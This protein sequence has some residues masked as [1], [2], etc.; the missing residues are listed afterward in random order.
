MNGHVFC[1]FYGGIDYFSY[2]YVGFILWVRILILHIF[3]LI[4]HCSLNYYPNSNLRSE[5]LP[6]I[7]LKLISILKR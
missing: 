5:D 4:H 7:N 2:C 1:P 3:F 6:R